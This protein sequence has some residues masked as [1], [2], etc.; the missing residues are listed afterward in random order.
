MI[1]GTEKSP[2]RVLLVELLP[3][4]S[5]G[6]A[7]PPGLPLLRLSMVPGLLEEAPEQVPELVVP[8]V[9]LAP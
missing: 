4:A 1:E 9:E 6:R 7:V 5:P 8:A 3:V 2:R